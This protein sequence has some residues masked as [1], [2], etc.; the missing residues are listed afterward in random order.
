VSR[1]G[2][3]NIQVGKN[4]AMSFDEWVDGPLRENYPMLFPKP[5]GSGATGNNGGAKTTPNPFKKETLNLTEQARLK[6]EDPQ[7]A[8]RLQSEAGEA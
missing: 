7:L 4:G 2:D 1:Y 8:A 3:G 5:T 6:S